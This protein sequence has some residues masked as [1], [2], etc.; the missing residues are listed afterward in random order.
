M[1]V[2][3]GK[4]HGR[5]LKIKSSPDLL[6]SNKLSKETNYTTPRN[7]RCNNINNLERGDKPEWTSWVC[8]DLNIV[9]VSCLPPETLFIHVSVHQNPVE[10]CPRSP[11]SAPSWPPVFSSSHL[12]PQSSR[13]STPHLFHCTCTSFT[14]WWTHPSLYKRCGL[15]SSEPILL[16]PDLPSSQAEDGVVRG[17]ESLFWAPTGS[18]TETVTSE[19]SAFWS[20]P[21]WSCC[22]KCTNKHVFRPVLVFILWHK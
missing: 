14:S 21:L 11:S 6:S 18:T 20:V 7:K 17:V 4:S 15:L 10:T 9:V 16:A 8:A 3:P 2:T 13:P 5:C 12:T 22:T 1:F 19:P